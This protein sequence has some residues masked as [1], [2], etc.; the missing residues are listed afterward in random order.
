MRKLSHK[1]IDKLN[2]FAKIQHKKRM[3][4]LLGSG[5]LDLVF[6]VTVRISQIFSLNIRVEM[7]MYLL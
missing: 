7:Y 4:S 1:H 3:K 2:R 6:K 5:D